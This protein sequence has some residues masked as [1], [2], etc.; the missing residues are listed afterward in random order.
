MNRYRGHFKVQQLKDLVHQAQ[1]QQDEGYKQRSAAMLK[2][3]GVTELDLDKMRGTSSA[4]GLNHQVMK[5]VTSE[6]LDTT[7]KVI[8]TVMAKTEVGKAIKCHISQNSGNTSVEHDQSELK[9]R[10]H[11]FRG[12]VE[13]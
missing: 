10:L 6:L 7:N 12:V 4:E 1:F 3:A 13:Q 5:P 9:Q 8:P 2:S 11:T